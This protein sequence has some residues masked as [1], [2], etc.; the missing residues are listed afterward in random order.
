MS[1]SEQN[2]R[3]A[4]NTIAL[5][6]RMGIT[7]IISFFA[8][9]VTLEVLGVED[10]GL[11]NVVAS[12]VAL[13]GFINGSMGTAVQRF[14]SIEIGKRNEEN[15]S[16]VFGTAVY[17][18]IIVAIIT[19]L[20]SE[21]FALLFLQKL[22]IPVDRM[23]A[24]KIV[25]QISIASMLVSII[26]VPYSA[27]LRSREEFSKIAV[28]DILQAFFRL[29]I[30]YLLYI[31]DI[32]KL[33]LLSMLNFC[34]SL[35]YFFGTRFIASKY[36]EV[37]FHILRDK[38]YT[39]KMV[40]FMGMLIMTV[41]ASVANKQGVVILV[42]LFF[43]L[44][45]NAAYAIAFQVSTII[46]TFAA[47][48]KQSIVPQIMES[49]GA[50]DHSRMHSLINTGTKVTFLLMMF[51]SIPAIFEAD[52][53]LKL[54]LQNPPAFS[55]TF[56]ILVI[57]SVNI[58]AY[59]YFIY[60]AVHASG[61]I[62]AQQTLTSISYFI[63]IIVLYISFYLGGDF[64]YAA[65]I[66]IVFSIVRNLI[67]VNSAIKTIKFNV[68]RY[69]IK[70]VFPSLLIVAIVSIVSYFITQNMDS[71][72]IRLLI[73]GFANTLMLLS[74]GLYMFF[75]SSERNRIY[76]VVINKSRSLSK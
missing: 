5:Y 32:D 20:I 7:M 21:V 51:I 49:Y 24:A 73:I 65:Y 34:I 31:V 62:K 41:L 48:F 53:L 18:H 72:I 66:P 56:T 74:L 22:N 69:F 6:I 58:D 45:I 28:L 17:L 54:W 43:G 39:K 47:N 37:K 12:I 1:N 23:F 27:V 42:N 15:L 61:R 13:F 57:I 3:I 60:Q 55:S 35:F 63:S 16:K 75:D 26:N 19:L 52:F 71:S 4:K 70:I 76:G 36:K 38:E 8:T 25:F 68:S 14:F 59:Y 46:E 10:Y 33:I 11:N 40:G 50:G 29:G 2:K 9:R 64:Y 30:L 44:T 67:V